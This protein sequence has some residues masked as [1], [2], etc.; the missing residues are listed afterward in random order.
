MAVSGLRKAGVPDVID[1]SGGFRE[2]EAA[3]LPVERGSG[4]EN[5]SCA[6]A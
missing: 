4:I 2:Y 5:Q 3:G 6:V 1:M